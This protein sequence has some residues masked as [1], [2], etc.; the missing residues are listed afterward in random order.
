MK[1]T[2]IKI[3]QDI[4][5]DGL[6]AQSPGYVRKLVEIANKNNDLMDGTTGPVKEIIAHGDIVFAVWQDPTYKCGVGLMV[7][8]GDQLL[9]ECIASGK[10]IQA[11][12]N[13]VKC[14]SYEMAVAAWNVLGV[15][16]VIARTRE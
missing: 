13:A 4:N 1:D 14:D 15:P 5:A 7:L 2:E 6:E 16:A 12:I 10:P 9:R 8:K 3:R 11:N